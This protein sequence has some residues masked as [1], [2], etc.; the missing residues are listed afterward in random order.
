MTIDKAELYGKFQGSVERREKLQNDIT[1]KALDLPRED[2]MGDVTVNN[3]ISGKA[4]VGILVGMAAVGGGGAIV[5]NQIQQQSAAPPAIVQPAEAE[6][7]I[8]HRNADGNIINVPQWKP[9]VQE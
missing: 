6:F 7:T 3:G 8:Q 5:M 2:D 9:G 4:L 1:R